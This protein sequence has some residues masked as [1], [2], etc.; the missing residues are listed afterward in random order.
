MNH[1]HPDVAELS[2]ELSCSDFQMTLKKK[3]NLFFFFLSL[4]CIISALG[5]GEN[6]LLHGGVGELSE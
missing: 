2:G 1:S 5:D 6:F 4:E 3:H